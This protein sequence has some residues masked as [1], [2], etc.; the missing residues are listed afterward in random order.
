MVQNAIQEPWKFDYSTVLFGTLSKHNS[1]L[2]KFK[3]YLSGFMFLSL[4]HKN[5]INDQSVH[6]WALSFGK[7]IP[8]YRETALHRWSHREI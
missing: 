1:M 2:G 8:Y 4:G 5:L 7:M 3:C 6:F